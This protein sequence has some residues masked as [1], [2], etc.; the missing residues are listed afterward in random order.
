MTVL[1]LNGRIASNGMRDILIFI[2]GS[3]FGCLISVFVLGLLAA[4]DRG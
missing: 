4:A 2:G 1:K 3:V